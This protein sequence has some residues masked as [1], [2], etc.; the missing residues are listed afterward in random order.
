MF[1]Y[2][3]VM[4]TQKEAHH[5]EKKIPNQ[6]QSKITKIKLQISKIVVLHLL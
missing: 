3:Q 5:T 4:N 2:F 1:Y 6:P